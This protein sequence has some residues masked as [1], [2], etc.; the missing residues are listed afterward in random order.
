MRRFILPGVLL[1]AGLAGCEG[2]TGPFQN[3]GNLSQIDNPRLSIPQQEALGRD[4]LALPDPTSILP[5]G[6]NANNDAG[7]MPGPSG[8]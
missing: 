2:T 5:G 6:K 4:R 3:R 7:L 1:L 8:R